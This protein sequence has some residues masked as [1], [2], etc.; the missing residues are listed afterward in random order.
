MVN[1]F[2]PHNFAFVLMKCKVFKNMR[3]LCN[4]CNMCKIK[5]IIVL[6]LL[7]VT[8]QSFGVVVGDIFVVN[9]ISYRVLSMGAGGY[10]LNAICAK[11]S[12]V[13]SIPREVQYG[14]VV[15][16]VTE[17][18]YDACSGKWGSGITTVV[19]PEG[20]TTINSWAFYG[21]SITSL[22]IPA[23][24]T[25]IDPTSALRDL[26]NLSEIT[27]A[28][29]NSSFKVED[30]VLYTMDGKG[31]VK[32]PYARSF[33]DNS[34]TIPNSV[35]TIYDA[36]I[37]NATLTTLT[38]G[39]GVSTMYFNF[40]GSIYSEHLP[41]L[42]SITVGSNSNFVTEDGVLYSSDK[43]K[44]ICFPSAKRIVKES[45]TDTVF[46]VPAEVDS[47]YSYAFVKLVDPN[48]R[49][50]DLN[51]VKGL[52]IEAI[53]NCS[54][55]RTITLGKGMD[56]HS[57]GG[58]VSN[59]R[60]SRFELAEGCETLVMDDNGLVYTADQKILL[61]CPTLQTDFTIGAPFNSNLEEIAMNAFRG[62]SEL[63]T[64]KI[65]SSVKVIGKEAFRKS[66]IM[67]VE[68]DGLDESQLDS[69]STS[70][71]KETN[72]TS[73]TVP[74][75][76]RYID[77]NSFSS[78][79]NLKSVTVCDGSQLKTIAGSAFSACTS[80]EKFTFLGT[81][82]LETI[83]SSAFQGLTS[84]Q[85]FVLPASVSVIG[86]NAFNGCTSCDV[87]FSN[88]TALKTIEEGAFA[89]CAINTVTFPNTL[90]SISA[91]AFR[92]C[93]QLTAVTFPAKTSY[94]S[95]E[96]FKHCT[97]LTSIGVSEDND[98]YSS[99]DGILLTK[100]KETLV[101]FPA[102][103]SNEE[104]T[105]LPPSITTIGAYSFYDC[106]NL[107]NVTIPNKVT[108]IG[109]RAFGLCSNLNT[110]TFLCDNKI[111]PANISRGSNTMSFDDGT[112][113]GIGNMFTNIN[114]NV[115]KELED[116]YKADDYY[117]Q[118]KN[119]FP[120]F[121]V[122]SDTGSDEEF[123]AVSDNAVDLLSTNTTDHTYILPRTVKNPNDG[124]KIYKVS[125]VGDYLFQNVSDAVKEVVVFD[126]VQ[127]IGSRAFLT[128][129][130]LTK[131]SSSVESLFFIETMPTNE[132]LS[133]TRF[134]LR[135]TDL[136]S[137]T[138]KMYNEIAAT[139]NIYVKKS[140]EAT[141]KQVWVDYSDQ[142]TYKVPGIAI[143]T[144]YGTFSREFDVDLSDCKDATVYAFTAGLYR[145][146]QNDYGA[147]TEY[148]IQM[149]SIN[150]GQAN[151]GTYIPANSGVMLKVWG[152]SDKTPANYYYCIGE[153][154]A[155]DNEPY[156]GAS[157]M[158]PMTVNAES[159]VSAGNMYVM[160]G[161]QW[162]KVVN[163][164]S[165]TIPVH[166]AYLMLPEV[167]ANAK[168]SFAFDDFETTSIDN[169]SAEKG[170][171]DCLINLQGQHVGKATKGVYIQNGRKFIVK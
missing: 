97:K 138:D 119:V 130:D 102:G 43:K 92:N 115:R 112:K 151:D 116:V 7:L 146:G 127:Y 50:I 160:S 159:V 58:I 22:T 17:V 55:L 152:D 165:V 79:E 162:H 145:K 5:A 85:A 101:L 47:I 9:G 72:I 168:V 120:S 150:S 141:Y 11:G 16:E 123:I 131:V 135:Q 35:E 169:V 74:R 111:D 62:C 41:K 164:K 66:S 25:T 13:V 149:S 94:I 167:P 140:A 148:I 90:K 69:I 84:L 110:I 48:L 75:S 125:L 30:G 8:T 64:V 157:V 40:P 161:G 95:P 23:S 108:T 10:K 77:A 53:K 57:I 6:F 37:D 129:T 78:C 31:L 56:K 144:K 107:T 81:C 91:D 137:S 2:S 18:G 29:G 133:T 87:D 15:F 68:Y 3:F 32:M 118:F 38:I 59:S 136:R 76:T 44:L 73:F 132:M 99:I 27:V 126:N 70:A 103:K 82:T 52:G 12:G 155:W 20:L 142:I 21:S 1:Q 71:F 60:L 26:N 61:F 113:S 158:N 117:Q 128:S 24:V 104:F 51:N 36:A 54:K 156:S 139:T 19:L 143:N 122:T 49:K 83:A 28:E 14:D 96:T 106:Q 124:D 80:L 86:A 63:T 153:N 100:N 171:D 42:E 4:I 163:G 67:S 45:A 89:D 114:I 33:M 88:N 170:T 65:P 109:D 46:T 121:V 134:K 93:M 98:T 34:F 39:P 154:A 105:L 166:K 147:E